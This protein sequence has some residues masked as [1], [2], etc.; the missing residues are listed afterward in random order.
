[1][2]LKDRIAE[3]M[4][5]AMKVGEKT[6]L[7]TLRTVKAALMER[8]IQARGEKKELSTAD[9]VAVV[10][11][12]A[13]KRKESIDLFT[14]GGRPELAEQEQRELEIIQEYLPR[15]MTAEE[16]EQVINKAME[17]TGATSPGDFP[18]VMPLVMK[19]VKGRADGKLV[20]E[21][22]RK[23]LEGTTPVG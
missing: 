14:K 21:L 19:E 5:Q 12:M 20:Q 3:D 9:E 22:V 2:G 7:E 17:S 18:K 1:M 11:S 23:R 16:I 8:E 13:K 4:K 6:R 10:M 15:M